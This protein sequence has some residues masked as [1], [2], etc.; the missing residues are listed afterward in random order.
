MEVSIGHEGEEILLIVARLCFDIVSICFDL[1]YYFIRS[2]S[3]LLPLWAV[4]SSLLRSVLL[5]ERL[6][7][8]CKGCQFGVVLVGVWFG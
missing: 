4:C 5:R 7:I 1:Y 2:G 6:F 8:I 3:V